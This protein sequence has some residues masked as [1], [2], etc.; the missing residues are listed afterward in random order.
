MSSWRYAA[1]ALVVVLLG[2]GCGKKSNLEASSASAPAVTGVVD[3]ASMLAYE[4]NVDFEFPL[5]SLGA[6][7]AEVRDACLSGQHGECELLEFSKSSGRSPA[8]T[9]RLRAEPKAIE[10]LLEQAGSGGRQTSRVTR[11]EDLA[12][13]VADN[14]RQGDQLDRQIS[15]L[16]ELRQREDLSVSDLLA[17]ARETS[18]LEAQLQAN[19]R[20]SAMQ[21][22]RLQTNLLTINFAS[23][24]QP[25]SK[26]SR[27]ADALRG[28]LDALVDGI[29]E[30]IGM[31]AFGLPFLL[32]AFPL[33]LAWRW[34]WRRATGAGR[35]Q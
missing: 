14:R 27:L 33:A 34:L 7:M 24:W 25:E 31:L 18:Q 26:S 16:S 32:V 29:E 35:R 1:L 20:A 10:P 23:K 6:H 4:H 3:E 2:S 12:R 11:A 28:S 5:G 22:R 30:V 8:G 15:L 13:A 17:L 21:S 9:L 19:E